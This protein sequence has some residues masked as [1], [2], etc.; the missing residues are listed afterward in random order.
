MPCRRRLIQRA[1][2]VTQ[3]L[4]SRAGPVGRPLR[5]ADEGDAA[6][7]S[8]ARRIDAVDGLFSTISRRSRSGKRRVFCS[9][10]RRRSGL[11]S[12]SCSSFMNRRRSPLGLSGTIDAVA[13]LLLVRAAGSDAEREIPQADLQWQLI[14]PSGYSVRRAGG[15]VDTDEIPPREMAAAK[16]G[17]VL[18]R[19]GGR[20]SAVVWRRQATSRLSPG[21]MRDSSAELQYPPESAKFA[22]AAIRG[23]AARRH[24]GTMPKPAEPAVPRKRSATEPNGSRRRVA[25]AIRGRKLAR[26]VDEPTCTAERPQADSSDADGMAAL[27]AELARRRQRQKRSGPWRVSARSRSTSSPIPARHDVPQS[28]RSAATGGDVIDQR[29]IAAAAWGLALLVFLVGM[30]LTFQPAR[31]AG[32]IRHRRPSRF[33]SAAFAHDGLR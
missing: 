16:V 15:T 29:R 13:P 32:V 3:S 6:G 14:L 22:Y 25:G 8:P 11:P 26:Q 23:S 4:G 20:H 17:A 31:Q 30:G 27:R 7:N 24:A 9:A 5:S 12:A 1:E 28:R 10:C 33:D 19:I 21:T 2:L 18:V